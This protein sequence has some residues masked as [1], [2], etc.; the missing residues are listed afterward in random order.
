VELGLPSGDAEISRT[1]LAGVA[2]SV[3]RWLE[4]VPDSPLYRSLS[5]GVMRDDDLLRIVGRIPNV[6]PMNLL[7]GAVKFLVRGDDPLA[8]WYPH[9]AGSARAPDDD[10]FTAFR[11]FVLDRADEVATIGRERRTQTN[12]VA[13]SAV[14][15]PWLADEARRWG[16]APHA[17][18]IGASAGLNLESFKYR[19]GDH[20]VG[21]GSVAIECENRGGFD[22]PD[23]LPRFASRTGLDLSPVDITDPAEAAWLEAL[24]WPEHLDRLSRLRAAIEVRKNAD[25]TMV[26][27]DA[28][29]TLLAV[30]RTL[31]PGPL[32]AWHTVAVYQFSPD[33]REALDAAFL[34]IATRREVA[35]VGLEPIPN[36]TGHWVSVGLTSEAAPI[37]AHAQS[38]GRWIDR[39]SRAEHPV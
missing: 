4:F 13:R 9:L 17:V 23:R 27:G 24:V 14:I 2:Q 30:E 3:R 28:T 1:H 32:L 29:E 19:Y 8:A 11:A 31:P 5:R 12:E 21:E 25:V 37:V 36:K 10:A 15:L 20:V 7:F 39:P 34:E 16:E 6:P 26:A 38:H 33:R 22:L 18:D 35:R